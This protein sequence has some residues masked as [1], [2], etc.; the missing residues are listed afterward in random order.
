MYK[1]LFSFFL[2]YMW[3]LVIIGLKINQK[4]LPIDISLILIAEKKNVLIVLIESSTSYS[5]EFISLFFYFTNIKC[6]DEK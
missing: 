1:Y 3:S 6:Q 5:T 2:E 4:E